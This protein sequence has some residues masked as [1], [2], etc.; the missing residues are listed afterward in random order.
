[1]LVIQSL[2]CRRV[3]RLLWDHLAHRLSEGPMEMVE[4]HLSGC[5][6]CRHE[7]AGLMQA[8]AILEAC[9]SKPMPMPRTSWHTLR[10]RLQDGPLPT[11]PRHA[12]WKTRLAT[13]GGFAAT[14]LAAVVTVRL[15]LPVGSLPTARVSAPAGC[16][17]PATPD[18]PHP[19]KD[20]AGAALPPH[21][22]PS[23]HFNGSTPST[24]RVEG[25]AGNVTPAFVRLT[26]LWTPDLF[27]SSSSAT[28]T[29]VRPQLVRNEARMPKSRPHS[30][31]QPSILGPLAQDESVQ[32][33]FR[34]YVPQPDDRLKE[35][36][37][38]ADMSDSD[39]H[40][41]SNDGGYIIEPL[42]PDDDEHP[43]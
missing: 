23:H 42:R 3:R 21:L 17:T 27:S 13:F 6:R 8:Q 35:H 22:L 12:A 1:M 39:L 43:Y 10:A 40:Q 32:S 18:R 26:D 37:P 11:T 34:H 16:C 41:V 33:Q 7:A 25:E 9:R 5:A 19:G 15:S 24:H 20:S 38:E 14:M 4:R 30:Q 36:S 31:P 28:A 2:H 29:D